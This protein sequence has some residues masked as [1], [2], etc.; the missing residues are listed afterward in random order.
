[1]KKHLEECGNEDL[2]MRYSK[3]E[4]LIK[5]KSQTDLSVYRGRDMVQIFRRFWFLILFF[6]ASYLEVY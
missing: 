3:M 5:K 2:I 4:E 6:R 1:V